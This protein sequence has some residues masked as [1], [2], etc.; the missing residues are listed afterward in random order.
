MPQTRDSGSCLLGTD[1]PTSHLLASAK[2]DIQFKEGFNTG[3]LIARHGGWRTPIKETD[4]LNDSG[5]I[6]DSVFTLGDN[7]ETGSLPQVQ[8]PVNV[9]QDRRPWCRLIRFVSSEPSQDSRGLS[10]FHDS[11]FFRDLEAVWHRGPDPT[12]SAP[13]QREAVLVNRNRVSQAHSQ[14]AYIGERSV[15]GIE[16]ERGGDS[17]TWNSV[18]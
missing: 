8:P 13:R 9:F 11:Y 10:L 4:G 18:R 12:S 2:R 5:Q 1:M 15:E 17:E 7:V 3:N 14:L 16:Y 6:Q